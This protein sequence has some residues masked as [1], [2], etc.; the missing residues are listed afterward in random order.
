MEMEEARGLGGNGVAGRS[1]EQLEGLVL[2]K[3]LVVKE[4]HTELALDACMHVCMGVSGWW[5]GGWTWLP[6]VNIVLY[7]PTLSR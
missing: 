6:L 7:V 2:R 5:V 3:A 4:V 1:G